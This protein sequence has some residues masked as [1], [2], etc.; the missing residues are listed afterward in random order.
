[1]V[2]RR[3]SAFWKSLH[4]LLHLIQRYLQLAGGKDYESVLIFRVGAPLSAAVERGGG[5]GFS[6]RWW[7]CQLTGSTRINPLLRFE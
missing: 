3:L 1:V 4:Y 7:A 2:S 6:F 5:F